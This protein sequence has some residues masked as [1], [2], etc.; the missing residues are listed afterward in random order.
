MRHKFALGRAH[1]VYSYVPSVSN[2]KDLT[3]ALQISEAQAKKV[4]HEELERLSRNKGLK[5]SIQV[6]CTMEK[7]SFEKNKLIQVVAWFASDVCMLI[8]QR[9]II[10]NLQTAKKMIN[11]RFDLFNREGSGWTL[12]KIN[13]ISLTTDRYALFQGGCATFPLPKQLQHHRG[14]ILVKQNIPDRCFLTAVAAALVH[15]KK[16]PSRLCT[17]YQ[18]LVQILPADLLTFPVNLKQIYHFEQETPIS[19]NIYG[20]DKI[21]FPYYVTEKRNKR[22]HVNLL[23]YKDH[24]YAIRNMSSL[25]IGQNRVNTRRTYVCNFCLSYFIKEDK[26]L[27]HQNLCSK[28]TQQYKIPSLS[29]RFLNFKNFRNSLVAPF[30]IYADFEASIDP[31]IISTEGKLLSK[32]YH[33]PLS[34]AALTVCRPNDHFSKP[35]VIYTGVDCI[36]VFFKFLFSESQYITDILRK[37]NIPIKTMTYKE[38]CSYRDASRCQICCVLFDEHTYLKVKDHCHLS[39]RYRQALCSRCNLTYAAQKYDIYVIMH[40]L[41]NYDSHFIVHNFSK[42]KE[43][44][45]KIVPRTSEKYLSFSLGNMHFKDSF[46]FLSESLATLVSNLKTKGVDSFSKVNQYITNAEQRECYYSKGFFPY[47]YI[48]NIEVLEEKMLPPKEAFYNDL[49]QEPIQDKN[50]AFAQKVWKIFGCSTLKDYLHVYLL[51]DCLL[52]ADCFEN[53]RTNCL[54]DY[55]LDP[56]YY[57]SNAHFTFD[58]FLKKSKIT[59]E[60]LTDINQYLFVSKGIRGGMSL[61][62]NRYSVANNPYMSNYDSSKEHIYIMDFDS[63][64]LYGYSMMDYLPYKDFT[65]ISPDDITLEHILSTPSNSPVG[66]ILQCTLAYPE[67]LHDQHSDYPLAP[68]KKSISY[69]KLS[70]CAR[71]ICD[72]HN[73][74]RSLGTEKLLG[75]L[76]TKEDYVVHYRTLQLYTSLGLVVTKV[77][78]ILGFGQGPVMKSYIDFNSDKRAMSNNDFDSTYYKFLSNS[79]FGKTMERPDNRTRIKLVNTIQTYEKY[80]SQLTFKSSKMINKNLVGLELKYPILKLNKPYYLGMAILEL[81]KLHMFNFHYNV[82][83]PRYGTN[84]KLLYTDTDSLIYEIKT[85]DIYQDLATFPGDYFD[86]SNYPP[87]HHLFSVKNKKVPGFFKDE[88]RGNQI[89][90]FVGLRSKMYAFRVESSNHDVVESKMAKG[91]KKAVINKDLKFDNYMQC[92]FENVQLEHD[93]KSIRSVGHQLFTSHQKKISLSPFDDKRWMVNNIQTI[94]YGHYRTMPDN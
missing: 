50:Y 42:Y 40:G 43:S 24:Y 67:H 88:S 21:I 87:D 86:F 22:Y 59:L 56:L 68:E 18:K 52:L 28:K 25:L 92:N 65:W 85:N 76:E 63:N 23:L 72:K 17:L 9:N 33:R 94:P 20:F 93:F 12:K 26:F 35:P 46:H 19:I 83:E 71:T 82:M 84:I 54:K 16:N 10:S 14:L 70:P 90:E 58:A 60:L 30:V 79:L 3:Q 13:L 11:E 69:S 41:S 78:G 34:F 2:S 45:I 62:S 37:V 64:N 4:L 29:D 39:G 1:Q 8:S 80:V 77:T 61:L 44:N 55:H 7:F 73:L 75:T 66:Y 6:K 5:F 49:A 89:V 74:K 51:A 31:K 32:K 53:F 48:D 27:L 36:D 47:S 81:S 57:F 38:I 91:V 15:K